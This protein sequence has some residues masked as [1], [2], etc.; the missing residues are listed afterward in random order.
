MSLNKK[1]LWEIVNPEKEGDKYSKAFDIF[2]L[3]LILL[4]TIAIIL[5][6]I[7]NIYE[8]FYYLFYYF[9]IFSIAIFTIEYVLKVW[10]C[11]QQYRYR[12]P[13]KGRLRFML[14]P[15]AIIDFMAFAPFYIPFFTYDLRFI[16]IIRFLRIIRLLKIQ[17]YLSALNIITKVLRKKKEELAVTGMIFTILV[18]ISSVMMFYAEHRVQPQEYSNVINSMWWSINELLRIE[19]MARPLTKLGKTFA[20]LI[21]I[22]GIAIIALPTSILSSGFTEVIV[23]KR[24]RKTC[25]HCGKPLKKKK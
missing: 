24:K 16:R 13:I 5:A 1:Y 10:L 21:G 14:T 18:I 15:Q 2:I 6:T 3:T 19:T 17:T 4:N 11:T 9:E 7:Q 20:S 22:L 23:K 25:P 8:Q 12:S